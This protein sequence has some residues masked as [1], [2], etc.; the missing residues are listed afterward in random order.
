MHGVP[1]TNWEREFIAECRSHGQTYRE[2]GAA[3]GRSY[4]SVRLFRRNYSK[5]RPEDV[6]SKVSAVVKQDDEYRKAMRGAGYRESEPVVTPMDGRPV[7][8][9]P[10]PQCGLGQWD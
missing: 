1:F 6:K 7:T 4:G 2:I 8:I 5:T 10:E 9:C 3:L